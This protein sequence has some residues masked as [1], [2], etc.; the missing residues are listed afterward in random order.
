MAKPKMKAKSIS[1]LLKVVDNFEGLVKDDKGHEILDYQGYVPD[2]FPGEHYGDYVELDI[3]LATGQITN[4]KKPKQKDIEK[5]AE[6]NRFPTRSEAD[7]IM[8]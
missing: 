2:F 6:Q 3:D 1:V 8:S 4:W 7:K 5:M